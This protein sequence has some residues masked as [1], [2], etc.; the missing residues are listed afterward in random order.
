MKQIKI[1]LIM[2]LFISLIVFLPIKAQYYYS[3]GGQI[4]I[5]IDSNKV[6]IKFYDSIPE[7]T[8]QRVTMS[9]SCLSEQMEDDYLIDNFLAFS[10]YNYNGYFDY[11]D[12]LKLIPEIERVEPY[13][14]TE[15][16]IPILMGLT[17]F[18]LF[19]E[20]VTENIIDSINAIYNVEIFDCPEGRTNV[21]YL[22]V[23]DSTEYYILDLA[24]IYFQMSQ[25]IYAH[26]DFSVAIIPDSYTL[27]D[28]YSQYQWHIKKVIG[29]FNEASVWD[30]AG[31]DKPIKVAVLD[32]GW[33][34]HPDLDITRIY[35]K[36]NIVD[37][38]DDVTPD[39]LYAHGMACTGIIAANH[40]TD[41]TQQGDKTT[42]MISMNSNAIIIPIKLFRL[43]CGIYHGS[44]YA[45]A[46]NYAY[47]VWHER[48]A[49]VI[50]CS[51]HADKEYDELRL[52][53][54]T[55]KNHG[56]N[57]LGCP[58][59]FSSGNTEYGAA[60]NVKYPARLEACFAVGAI[61]SND[62]RFLYSHYDTTLDI[63]APSGA[64]SYKPGY[65][66]NGDVWTLDQT[67]NYGVNPASIHSCPND[68][69]N[70]QSMY[71]KFGGTSAACPVVSG[72]AS[73]ILAK[74][75]TLTANEVYDILRNSAVKD[76]D[77]GTLPDTPHVEYGYGRVDAFRAILSI[78]HGDV[79]NDDQ[80]DMSDIT[81]LIDY[82]YLGGERPFP[83]VLMA[84][85]NCD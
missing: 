37:D 70:D 19:N 76:L 3:G 48:E 46:I 51:W 74:D 67:S 9:L 61:D 43:P 69:E 8:K 27:Y 14:L 78:S 54:E 72:T 75:P 77:W 60:G 33:S 10:L 1:T 85:C 58:V 6:T 11:L 5:Q 13:Y 64:T 26:P 83:S 80:I 53:I 82:L 21:Y 35:K 49:D 71:C 36:W 34:D 32:D 18:V 23:T 12:S 55:A 84:D 47:S 62:Y 73:L 7:A 22:K 38:T 15:D 52:E 29:E 65:P 81:A 57:G 44:L 41:S 30:F 2:C 31:L 42:G 16:S 66:P 28:Y 63:V 39:S 59:I 50:S 79:T 68:G 4:P 20:D 45:N 24:N 25:T 17:I 40:T 56:R